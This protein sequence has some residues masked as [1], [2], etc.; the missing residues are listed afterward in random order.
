MY[1]TGKEMFAIII[2]AKHSICKICDIIVSEK[3]VT[4]SISMNL[5]VSAMKM[6]T[7]C[8][9]EYPVHMQYHTL[10]VN[11]EAHFRGRH[12]TM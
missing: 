6:I 9:L 8:T 12:F 11:S 1:D 5:T 2:F 7:C 3:F 10:V 4:Y